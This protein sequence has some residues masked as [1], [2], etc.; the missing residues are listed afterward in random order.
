MV[1]AGFIQPSR[2]CGAFPLGRPGGA[3][4][5]ADARR[6]EEAD[7][8]TELLKSIVGQPFQ[9]NR[10]LRNRAAERLAL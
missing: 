1:T 8:P 6:I 3:V 2:Q 9:R 7:Q 10:F 4:G 5:P